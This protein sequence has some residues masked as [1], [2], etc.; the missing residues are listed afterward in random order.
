MFNIPRELVK[1]LPIIPSQS[2]K[3]KYDILG[4]SVQ[5]KKYKT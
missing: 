1:K 2:D 3:F 4:I 5:E